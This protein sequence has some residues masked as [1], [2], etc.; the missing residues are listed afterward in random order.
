VS[1]DFDAYRIL[2]VDPW[3]SQDEIDAAFRRLTETAGDD[4]RL[5]L[6]AAYRILSDPAERRAYDERRVAAPAEVLSEIAASIEPASPSPDNWAGAPWRAAEVGW[7]IVAGIALTILGS[8]PFVA[9]AVA[10]A[11]D[12]DEVDNDP[13]ALAISLAGSAV[14]Q[15]AILGAVWWFA[16][17]KHNLRWDALGLRK[18]VRGSW[19]L[20]FGLFLGAMVIVAVYGLIL[21]LLD[22]EPDTDLPDAVYDNALP[23]TVAFILTVT[24]API[25][26]EIF[27]RGFVFRGL[28]TSWGVVWG[29]AASAC[30][31]GIAHALNPDG[32]Y[33]IAA[34]AGIGAL[35]AWGAYWSRSVLPCIGA[36]FLFNL[37]QMIAATLSNT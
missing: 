23:L 26:E 10:V 28:A 11:G 20:P 2:Q 6:E 3:A 17:R 19:W 15:F 22:L 29:G 13:E 8:I 31:F 34:I 21:T 24:V 12:A 25:I 30:L 37:F 27:F 7:A 36:H 14:F 33:V 32:I 16:L 35:F 9:A 5:E 18:P 4:H 1:T